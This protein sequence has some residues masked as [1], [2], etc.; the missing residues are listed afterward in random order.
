MAQL[1]VSIQTSE[2]SHKSFM[3]NSKHKQ[4]THPD[5][6]EQRDARSI[7]ARSANP[8]L[9]RSGV[10]MDVNTCC[11]YFC[12]GMS[13]FGVIGL[14]I[15]YTILQNGGAWY[16]G[17]SREEAPHAANAC[18]IA[19]LIYLVYL[20]YCGMKIMKTNTLPRDKIAED[21]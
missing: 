20:I 6:A 16:L 7:T 2:L 21:D 3:Q 10:A 15:F 13:V 11:A 18:L 19:A 1:P 12:T 8:L 14:L 17:V 4:V 5:V 9:A